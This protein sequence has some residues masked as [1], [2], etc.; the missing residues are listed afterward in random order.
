M[1]R[2]YQGA[3]HQVCISR[4]SL[5]N[6]LANGLGASNEAGAKIVAIETKDLIQSR[7]KLRIN[8]VSFDK[9]GVEEAKVRT[10]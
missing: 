5:A 4:D 2:G 6:D 9:I 1:P 3:R 7:M 10:R 8:P